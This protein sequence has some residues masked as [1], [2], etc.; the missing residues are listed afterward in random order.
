MIFRYGQPLLENGMPVII[1]AKSEIDLKSS[2]EIFRYAQPI[3]FGFVNGVEFT[4]YRIYRGSHTYNKDEMKIF[5]DGIVEECRELGIDTRTPD[6]IE[7]L[8]SLMK[9]ER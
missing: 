9:E 7:N 4:H 8:I 5:I 1:S 3:G 2:S 6:E